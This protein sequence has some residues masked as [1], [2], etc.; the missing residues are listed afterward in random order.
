MCRP[1]GLCYKFKR[2]KKHGIGPESRPIRKIG[3][4]VGPYH[5]YGIHGY[6][7]LF[8]VILRRGQRKQ[9]IYI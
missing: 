7:W 4:L 6:P 9:F 2:C 5:A 1:Y 3:R 8:I